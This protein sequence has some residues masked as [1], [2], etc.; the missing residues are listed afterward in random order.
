MLGHAPRLLLALTV[1]GFGP[2]RLF[3]QSA[4]SRLEVSDLAF[5][6]NV[7]FPDDS[8]RTAI[9]NRET[10]CRPL[11]DFLCWMGLDFAEQEEFLVRRELERDMTRLR[12]YYSERGYREARVDTTVAYDTENAATS[13]T[14][15]I[16][17]GTP[18]LIDSLAFVG[19]DVL[20]EERL[21]RSLPVAEG[22]PLS[23][24]KL[25]Q[26]RDSLLVRLRNAG[27]V[28]ADVFLQRFIPQDRPH[29][30]QVTY[31]IDPGP[32]ARV[33]AL[34]IQVTGPAE[35]SEAVVR[36]MLPFREG[37]VYS[38]ADVQQGQR[39]LYNLELVRNALIALDTARMAT[40][41]DTLVPLLV[42]VGTNTLHRVRLGAGWNRADCISAEARWASRNVF[43]GAQRLEVSGRVSNLLTERIEGYP[44]T[45]A[46]RAEFGGINW[47]LTTELNFPAVISP[48]NA[49][50]TSVFWERQ[51]LQDVFIREGVGVNLVVTRSFRP[52]MPLSVSYRPQRTGLEAAGIFFCTSLL[53]CNPEDIA[54]LEDPNWLSPVG[55]AVTRDRTDNPLNPS[56]GY[57]A[58]IEL[59]RADRWTGSDFSYTRLLAE[60]S[61]YW[62]LAFRTVFAARV[63]SGW[64]GQADFRQVEGSGLQIV[65]PQKRFFVGGANSV[66]GF[67]QN[68]LGPRVLTVDYSQL[69]GP[70]QVVGGDTV[71]VGPCLPEEIVSFECD[72]NDLDDDQFTP[73]PTGGTRLLEGNFEYRF[74]VSGDFQAVT[75]VDFGQVWG[76]RGDFTLGE[77]EWTPGI[78]A[79][80]FSPIGPLRVDVAYRFQGAEELLAVTSRIRRFE[81]DDDPNDRIEIGLVD[82][83]GKPLVA[84]GRT[85]TIR[86]PWVRLDELALLAPPV[87]F[88]EGDPDASALRRFFSRLQIHLSIGQAF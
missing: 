80:Y 17:E 40:F 85:Q 19:T 53:V 35:L 5:E 69:V 51:S 61:R 26:T 15:H 74:A 23:L 24:I 65:A 7:V 47:A 11:F 87:T 1:T 56:S 79:R 45:Y 57:A 21:L 37:S 75:F 41:P 6:G 77:L 18:V 25:E 64:V 4:A 8:L 84:D 9:I 42:Q 76:E 20:G 28:H 70:A 13:I 50:S 67:A 68:R 73:R 14:F 82:E 49:L 78:G 81:T 12:I 59:E 31:D 3:A 39:N 22:D 55:I 86:I 46:G 52:R 60:T 36:E 33:G 63:R 30:A 16:Q 27:F 48:R 34:D 71:L 2:G 58:H 29:A 62:D 44:C 38:D 10:E 32:L 66:R 88:G 43:G 72:A 83:Q 54:V